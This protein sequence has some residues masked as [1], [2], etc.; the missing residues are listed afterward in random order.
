MAVLDLTTLANLKAFGR[1]GLSGVPIP[2]GSDDILSSMITYVSQKFEQYCSRGFMLEADVARRILR[3][4]LVPVLREP[5][6]SIAS[7][8]IAAS[9]R[10]ADLVTVSASQYEI[11]PDGGSVRIFDACQG[12]LVVVNYTGGI[13]AATAD[14]ITD[15]PVLEGACKLQT[16]NLWQ[17]HT[18]PDKSGL[19]VVSGNTTW[20]G[21]YEMLKDVKAD[22]DQNYNNKHR[23]L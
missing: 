9:G 22:L 5:I 12:S 13:A 4:S 11:H 18:S 23:F 16:L 3:G 14:I 7:V 8:Q 19:T 10:T 21:Q 1:I 15:H 17:R 6:A 20:E 2:A